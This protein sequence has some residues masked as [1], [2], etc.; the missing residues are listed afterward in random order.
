MYDTWFEKDH[1]N[2]YSEHTDGVLV[3]PKFFKLFLRL[4][5]CRVGKCQW[6]VLVYR[7]NKEWI[8]K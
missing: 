8:T 1:T 5:A 6:C 4:S 7:Y 3:R 2:K